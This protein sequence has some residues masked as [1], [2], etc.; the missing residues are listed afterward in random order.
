MMMYGEGGGSDQ[1]S[2]GLGQ[3]SNRHLIHTPTLPPP[4]HTN[5]YSCQTL[6]TSWF[7]KSHLNIFPVV[8]ATLK[9]KVSNCY[10]KN[11]DKALQNFRKFNTL[12]I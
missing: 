3:A 2:L 9:S 10:F 5:H 6:I 1:W 11:I 8:K 12:G 4:L 7:Q